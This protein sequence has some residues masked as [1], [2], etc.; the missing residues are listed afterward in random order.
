MVAIL[1]ESYRRVGAIAAVLHGV[2][3]HI[4]DPS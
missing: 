3:P 2:Q 1:Y 4:R